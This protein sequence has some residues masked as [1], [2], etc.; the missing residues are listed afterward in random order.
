MKRW[1]ASSCTVLA[2]ASASADEAALLQ[3]IEALEER[4]QQLESEQVEEV[5]RVTRSAE[6]SRSSD[7]TRRIRL[8]GSSDAGLFGGQDSTQISND[9][10]TIWD[11]RFFL[12]ADLGRDVQMQDTTLFRDIGF[13]FEWNLVRLGTLQNNVGNLYVDF[14]GVADSDWMNAQVGRFQIPVGEA[15]LDYSK[16]YATRAFVTN[17][18]GPWY[19]DEGVKL[20]SLSGAGL[21]GYVAS[22]ENG[23]TA[24]NT[25]SDSDKQVTLKLFTDPLPWLHLSVSGLRSGEI[26]HGGTPVTG[27]GTPSNPQNQNGNPAMGSLW[28]GESWA[29]AFGSGTSVPNFENGVAV[30]D[31]PNRLRETWLAAGDAIVDFED[32]IRLWGAYGEYKIDS[33]GPTLYD[34]TLAYWIAEVILRGAWLGEGLRPFYAGA[35]VQ[36][37]GTTDTDKG[38]LLD[39]RRSSDLGYNMHELLTYSGVFGWDIT[40]WLIFR[41]EYT[42]QDVDVV[43][44]VPDS[45]RDDARDSD[46]W[47]VEL[48][49]HF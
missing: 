19:W 30:A 1:I 6:E 20:Y 49:G 28:L 31:G 5:H 44:G 41:T 42:H 17:S 13:D 2:A 39:F 27:T 7:W 45:I 37:L 38:Y 11:A 22:V 33:Q 32:K 4:V 46:Y 48:G 43:R 9:A 47:A 23:D 26:G 15:Y 25:D 10:F 34:R 36:S 8:S 24:F 21:F 35:R 14:Q 3:K 16:G 18:F 12:D 29:R 40:D